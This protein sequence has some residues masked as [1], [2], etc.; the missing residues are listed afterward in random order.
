LFL[1]WA[2][3]F[4]PDELPVYKHRVLSLLSSVLAGLFAF[5]LSGT[6]ILSGKPKLPFIGEI[7]LRAT[8][9]IA[10]FALTMFW[11]S[12][13]FSPVKV[14]KK[15]AVVPFVESEDIHLGDNVYPERWGYSHNPLNIAIYPQKAK[16][17]VYFDKETGD[18]LA[19]KDA[20]THVGQA[21]VNYYQVL[22]KKLDFSGYKYVS[23]YDG[24]GEIPALLKNYLESGQN[25][26][27][28]KLGPT[29]LYANKD[30]NGNFYDRYAAVGVVRAIDFTI[31]LAKASIEFGQDKLDSVEFLIECYHGGIRP[32]QSQNFALMLNGNIHEIKT[33]SFNMR[34]KEVVRTDIPLGHINF[35]QENI[36]A[37]FVLPWQEDGPRSFETDNGPVHFRDVG[38]V[39]AYFK[40]TGK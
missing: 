16:G 35:K 19:G 18:F 12:S 24:E 25:N 36:A 7:T 15:I 39:N 21:F 3:V 2:F 22:V 37:L 13:D 40:T 31:P 5:F 33:I 26:R 10:I 9:G 30:N 34:E 28:I 29:L 32:D 27:V 20:P 4:A 17:L 14:Q 11:W 1:I 23:M 38:I 6:M 8:S